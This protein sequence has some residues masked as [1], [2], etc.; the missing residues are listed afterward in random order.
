MFK[1][2]KRSL[3]LLSYLDQDVANVLKEAIKVIDFSVIETWRSKADQNKYYD[4]GRSKLRW[5][6]S[7]HNTKSD[8]PQKVKAVDI[9]PYP[10]GWDAPKEKFYFMM[11]I[12]KG[13]AESKGI[14]LR[15][16][17]DWDSDNEFNDQSFNDFPHIE[18]L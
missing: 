15:F 13:I 7:K 14:K 16:G 8:R 2:S 10:E 17:L 4:Q 9:I 5:P 11:G 3:K 6:Q 12:I 1:F 18:K